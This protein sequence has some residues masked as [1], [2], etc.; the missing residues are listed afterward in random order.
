MSRLTRRWGDDLH[1][2]SGRAVCKFR[3]CPY[4][5]SCNTCN[6]AK[7]NNRLADYE[8]KIPYERLDEA[9]R[10]LDA[11]DNNSECDS[12]NG[13]YIK[14]I[15]LRVKRFGDYDSDD[16][17]RSWWAGYCPRCFMIARYNF[18]DSGKSM[19]QYCWKCGQLCDF[20]D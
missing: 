13:I 6:H 5:G 8:D 20:E 3:E 10:L 7:V 14:D 11:R 19:Q 4:H 18:M 16:P 9:A 1:D 12:R 17:R 2:M 15:P